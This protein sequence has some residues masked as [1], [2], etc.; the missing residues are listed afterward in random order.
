MENK[1]VIVTVKGKRFVVIYNTTAESL[2][3]P[4]DRIDLAKGKKKLFID[5]MHV[6][7][8]TLIQYNCVLEIK[9]AK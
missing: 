1:W 8:D 9:D 3:S 4:R 7:P 5:G 2:F 6:D